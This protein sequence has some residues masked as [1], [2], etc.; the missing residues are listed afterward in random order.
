MQTRTLTLAA[1]VALL[2]VLPLAFA[3]GD[4]HSVD[5]AEHGSVEHKPMTEADVA[6]QDGWPMS[7]FSYSEHVGLLWTYVALT[8]ITWTVV[9]PPVVMLSVA[10]SRLTVPA[11]FLFLALQGLTLF[12]G[13]IYNAKTPDFYPNNAHDKLRWPLFFITGIWTFLGLVNFYVDRTKAS[14]EA[15]QPLST[16]VMARYQRLQQA[17]SD[18]PRYSH[19]SGQ[20]TERNSSSLFGHSRSP[21]AES[22]NIANPYHDA[23]LDDVEDFEEKRDFL[24]NS[25]LDRLM[26]RFVPRFAAGRSLKVM[27]FFYI[28]IERT[29]LLLGFVLI[30]MGTA[31][32]GGI[33]R[34][35]HV[36][37]ILA[38]YVKG[39]I[40]FWYGLLT[41]GRWMGCFADLGWAWNVKPSQ[42]LVGRWKARIP[43]AEFTESFVIFTYGASNVFL[44]HLAAW[45][46]AWTAQ[47]L[48]HVSI[49]VMFFGG[50]ALGMLIES[51]RIREF[52]NAPILSNRDFISHSADEKWE[53]PKTYRVSLNPMPALVILLLG[54]MMGSHHQA[55]ML[56]SMIHKQWGNMFVGFAMARSVTYIM[57]YLAPPTSLLPARPPSEIVSSFCLVAGGI[58]FMVSNKDTVGAMESMDLDAMF[59]FVLT[60]GLTALIMA[61]TVVTIALKGWAFRREHGKHGAGAS[62]A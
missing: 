26:S 29:I 8:V 53:Q 60:V 45:G 22:D 28:L 3:H 32:L 2:Q 27:R 4:D 14:G 25:R 54:S 57:L 39:A 1:A 41:L 21:S 11:Q 59:T 38:H 62:L 34:G 33:S 13:T 5:M 9:A 44:E 49:S 61:W 37:N 12:V 16:A 31:T 47:D 42:E 24:Q 20:G 23:D 52:L 18:H 48:E 35:N 56:S 50:G 58:T 10:R 7:Y 17:S 43:S 6:G 46:D 30:L 51:K 19:D 55:S 15:S 36:F 40:F